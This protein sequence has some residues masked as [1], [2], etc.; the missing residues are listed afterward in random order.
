[1]VIGR[2]LLGICFGPDLWIKMV[3]TSLYLA[4]AESASM[5]ILKYIA[6]V[7]LFICNTLL[8]VTPSGPGA[9]TRQPVFARAISSGVTGS[10]VL[11][12]GLSGCG[13]KLSMPITENNEEKCSSTSCDVGSS[14]HEG[15]SSLSCRIMSVSN[16]LFLAY[17]CWLFLKR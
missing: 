8:V 13:G 3:R 11:V 1:M 16:F 6:S 12:W 5:M 4:G 9:V 10:H 7:L 17:N 15:L 14:L 2:Q